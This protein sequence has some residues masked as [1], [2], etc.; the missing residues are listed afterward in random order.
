MEMCKSTV[1]H[2]L[3][4]KTLVSE[5]WFTDCRNTDKHDS[6][7]H[8]K[9]ND[10]RLS[11]LWFSV[12]FS[13]MC[14]RSRKST[15]SSQSSRG[16]RG[17]LGA[18]ALLSRLSPPLRASKLWL[19]AALSCGGLLQRWQQVFLGQV[20]LQGIE[21]VELLIRTEGQE[22]LDHLGGVRAPERRWRN[23]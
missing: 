6:H 8:M 16:A 4:L 5:T 14:S 19:L 22:L 12:C 18:A 9:W 13:W 15:E 23:A 2:K 10:P 21:D 17:S 20:S 11:I 7:T 1:I 3:N